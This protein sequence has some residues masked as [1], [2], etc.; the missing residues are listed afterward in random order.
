[1]LVDP[2]RR[3]D[4]DLPDDVHVVGADELASGHRA[5]FTDRV[6]GRTFRISADSFFQTRTDGAEALVDA[7]RTRG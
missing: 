5:W 2:G 1:M 3:G 6:A 7:V 4:I